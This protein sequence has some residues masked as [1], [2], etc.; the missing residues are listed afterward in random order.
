MLKPGL[1]FA[2]GN[3]LTASDVAF[4]L[5]R[6]VAIADSFGPSVLLGNFVK[7]TVVD[8]L[9]ID[10]EVAIEYDQTFPYALSSVAGAIVDEE[11][12][13]PDRI[14]SNDEIVSASPFAGPYTIGAFELNEVI[15]FL[16]NTS[17]Q[18][19]WQIKNSGV[20]LVNFD[21]PNNMVLNFQRGE[22]DLALVYRTLGSSELQRLVSDS[23]FIL[24]SGDA[25]E[26]G[27]IAFHFANAPF[28]TATLNPDPEKAK[29]VRQAMA[30][31]IGER[32]IVDEVFGDTAEVAHTMVPSKMFGHFPSFERYGKPDGSPDL[33]AAAETLLAAG[34]VEPVV[35]DLTY[36]SDRFGQDM[37]P[38]FAIVK[39]QLEQDGLF[40]VNLANTDSDSWSS[41]RREGKFPVWSHNW[42]PDYGDP[43]NYLGVIFRTGGA[44]RAE[45]SNPELDLLIAKESSEPDADARA[46]LLRQIQIIIAED[47]PVIP[48]YERGRSVIAQQAIK[49]VAETLDVSFKFRFANLER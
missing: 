20:I 34:I 8:E 19:L 42:G 29:A 28:G 43:A 35:I 27:F 47:V 41:G 39:Q 12:F 32:Q 2:N 14:M 40:Q 45:Y 38:A 48:I 46:E 16:P 36:S 3:E 30:H 18:G 24:H 4:S 23:D 33:E 13:A 11:I 21:D 26:P 9:T 25:A 49:G 7:A 5:A 44:L 10:I 37:V 15:E 17:Y 6:Q 1:K 31:L 22:I